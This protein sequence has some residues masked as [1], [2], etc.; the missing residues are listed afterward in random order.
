MIFPISSLQVCGKQKGAGAAIRNFG[1]GSGSQFNF[2][3]AA[4]GFAS[5]SATLV[6]KFFFVIEESG[7]LS[8]L[9]S[10]AFCQSYS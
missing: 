2:G 7:R 8:F 9:T 10:E 6:K 4:L 5:G 3:F 1:S